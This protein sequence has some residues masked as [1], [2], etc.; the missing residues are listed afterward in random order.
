[1]KKSPRRTWAE[2]LRL[3]GEAMARDLDEQPDTWKTLMGCVPDDV[4]VLRVL[5]VVAWNRGGRTGEHTSE[6]ADL[7]DNPE[8]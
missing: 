7:S 5:D 4:S 1:M 3:L 8:K 6:P 2:F